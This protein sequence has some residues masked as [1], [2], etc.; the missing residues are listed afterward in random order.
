MREAST[1]SALVRAARKGDP[2]AFLL[3][4]KRHSTPIY[5]FVYRF[6]GSEKVAEDLTHDCFLEFVR[7]PEGSISSEDTVL[8][9][10]YA[11][12][13]KLVTKYL[14][15]R[16]NAKHNP[17]ARELQPEVQDRSIESVKR[18]IQDLPPLE[19]ETLILFEYEG[20]PINQIAKIVE[21]DDA[22]VRKRLNHARQ[23]LQTG[24]SRLS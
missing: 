18:V 6:L 9:Q 23:K 7:N 22:E 5:R 24:L 21:A 3:L 15:H 14:S 1:D 4:F 2:D 8:T 13:R 11:R 17:E 10:L 16:E 19:R 20:V 12:A